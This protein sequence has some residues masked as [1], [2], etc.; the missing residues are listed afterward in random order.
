MEL[1]P[2]FIGVWWFFFLKY[3]NAVGVAAKKS[4]KSVADIS[5]WIIDFLHNCYVVRCLFVHA[6]HMHRNIVSN[7]FIKRFYIELTL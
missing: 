6:I 1:E 3:D 2:D 7:F 4:Y 5:L